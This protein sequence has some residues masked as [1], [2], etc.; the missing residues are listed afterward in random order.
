MVKSV[1]LVGNSVDLGGDFA[2]RVAEAGGELTEKQ[3]EAIG[4]MVTDEYHRR[5]YTACYVERLALTRA[6]V[7][8][9]RVRESRITEIDIRGA[10][11][12]NHARAGEMLERLRGRVYNRPE[13]EA[14]LESMRASLDLAG[15]ECTPRNAGPG[16]ADVR[17]DV[18][19]RE[20]SRGR[21]RGALYADPIY[22][23][24]PML[25]YRQGFER[26]IVDVRG[27]AGF[28]DGGTA[29][30]EGEVVFMTPGAARGT[31][32]ALAGTRGARTRELWAS[33]DDEEYRVTD[34]RA[35]AGAGFP[36]GGVGR[37]RAEAR[38]FVQGDGARLEDYRERG[39]TRDIRDARLV[40]EA[41]LSDAAVVLEQRDAFTLRARI[42]PGTGTMEPDGYLGASL[43]MRAPLAPAYW[44]R[45]IPSALCIY[46]SARERYYRSYVF[47]SSMMGFPA[48]YT[49]S[50]WKNVGA[51]EAELE[52]Y[53]DFMYAG[54][55][56]NAAYYLDERGAWRSATGAGARLT[57][58]SGKSRVGIAYAWDASGPASK[59]ALYVNAMAAF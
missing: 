9:V 38:V 49:A 23:I 17:L 47:D 52:L 53:P 58:V 31:A 26:V 20:R 34:L 48:D 40:F 54:P 6:G 43:T 14:A 2:A 27:E 50:R 12:Q 10:A 51:L 45:I 32:Y 21:F 33:R 5:G 55:F 3:V 41:T 11:R 46:T 35:Y 4:V 18:A 30:E 39:R 44:L 7:L 59:G 42:E 29:R 22:G 36:I 37:A 1:V 16:G 56:V 19:V 8:E 15:I 28:R 25:G 13:V 24:S 57:L